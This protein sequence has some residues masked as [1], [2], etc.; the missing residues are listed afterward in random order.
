MRHIRLRLGGIGQSISIRMFAEDMLVE[1][2]FCM[3]TAIRCT[4]DLL[5]STIKCKSIVARTYDEAAVMRFKVHERHAT[6]GRR[7]D[8]GLRRKRQFHINRF[9]DS[10]DFGK[11]IL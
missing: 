5:M 8:R 11:R 6:N 3:M 10:T 9:P 1:A 2:K 4:P 7:F